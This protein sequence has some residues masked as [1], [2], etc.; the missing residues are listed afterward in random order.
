MA[1]KN[2]IEGHPKRISTK[3]FRNRRDTFGEEDFQNCHDSMIT[4]KTAPLPG[5]QVAIYFTNQHG[6]NEFYREGNPNI[7]PTRLFENWQDTFGE[8]DF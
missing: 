5:L 2:L 4:G 8:E 6:L 3:L 7:I 1:L